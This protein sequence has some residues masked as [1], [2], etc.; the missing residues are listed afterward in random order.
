M[1]KR[2]ASAKGAG[3]SPCLPTSYSKKLGSMKLHLC[4][5][6][7]YITA[8]GH[9]EHSDG[10]YHLIVETHKLSHQTD[11][12]ELWKAA[13]TGRY[14]KH[15]LIDLR[16]SLHAGPGSAGRSVRH[17]T[18]ENDEELELPSDVDEATSFGAAIFGT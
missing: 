16:G 17:D 7:S 12:K 6:K 11:A 15:D 5:H 10:K 9:S 14:D 8:L 13:K 4:T 2:P 18:H 3:A 1:F